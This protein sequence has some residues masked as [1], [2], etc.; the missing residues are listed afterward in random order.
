M[1]YLNQGKYE[2]AKKIC[3]EWYKRLDNASP[4][5]KT[6]IYWLYSQCFGTPH[7][8]I[9]YAKQL[10]ELDDQE[11]IP[12]FVLGMSYFGLDQYENGIPEYEK[13]LKIYKKLGITPSWTGVFSHLGW[14][15]LMT[16]QYGKARRLYKTMEK[17]FPD[18]TDLLEGRAF[19]A[20]K[21][22]DN[23]ESERYFEKLKSVRKSQLWSEARILTSLAGICSE[24]GK[25]Q[26]AEEIYRQALSLEPEN[27][28]IMNNLAYFLIDKDRN[29]KE[30][31]ELVE[32]ALEN[33][34]EDYEFLDTKGWG[35][36]KLGRYNEASAVLQKSWDLR[37]EMAVYDHEAFL[38]LEAAKNAV[39]GQKRTDR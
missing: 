1:S 36:Y 35:L 4:Q 20:L 23:T 17:G 27:P 22:G 15:Y 32:M 5:L 37:R 29:I 10:L 38:H 9:N 12:H 25:F 28:M 19:L 7:D 8:G 14:A 16:G 3:L 26:K 24:A 31:M 34:P 18:N 11:P 33:N 30:G 2:K 6:M 13:A 39:A 21:D